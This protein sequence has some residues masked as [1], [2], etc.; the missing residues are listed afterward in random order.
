MP[1]T[2]LFIG[3][4]VGK[5]GRKAVSALLPSLREEH[6]IDLVIANAENLAH[7]KGITRTTLKEIQDAGVDLCTSGNHVWAK[8]EGVE[9]LQQPDTSLLRPANYPPKTPGVGEKV[10][11]IATKAILVINLMGRD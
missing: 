1:L 8:P 5:A 9:L 2:I 11:T 7:G 3:D 6:S 4:I 10:V